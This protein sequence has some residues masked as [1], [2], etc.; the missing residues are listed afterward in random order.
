MLR[1]VKETFSIPREKIEK[2][3]G[4]CCSCNQNMS[5]GNESVCMHGLHPVV[6]IF[7]KAKNRMT[8]GM[9]GASIQTPKECPVITKNRR[10]QNMFA[11]T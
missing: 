1:R 9:T 8:G 11:Q 3:L 2:C 7:C 10:T 4:V 5:K 6:K